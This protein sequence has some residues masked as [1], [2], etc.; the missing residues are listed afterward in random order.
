MLLIDLSTSQ[1][2]SPDS[3]KNRPNNRGGGGGAGHR[4]TV[5]AKGQ[6]HTLKNYEILQ[7]QKI[8]IIKK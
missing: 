8:I 6:A 4:F 1:F 2:L 7:I 3:F 5:V